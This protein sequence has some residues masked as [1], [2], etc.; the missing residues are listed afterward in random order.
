M[1]GHGL[2]GHLLAG[3][4]L[5]CWLLVPYISTLP[6]MYAHPHTHAQVPDIDIVP[7]VLTYYAIV[8]SQSL[9]CCSGH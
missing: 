3:V 6:N 7:F 5:A 8:S 9:F 2:V 4:V 1:G